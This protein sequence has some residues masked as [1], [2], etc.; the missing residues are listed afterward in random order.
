VTSAGQ[1]TTVKSSSLHHGSRNNLMTG[2]SVER[3]LACLNDKWGLL[4]F[5]ETILP[6]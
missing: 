5:L 1:P 3:Q 6:D 4:L 2:M